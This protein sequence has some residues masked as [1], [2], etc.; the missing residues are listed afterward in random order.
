MGPATRPP[1]QAGESDEA[2]R[3]P[4]FATPDSRSLSVWLPRSQV[5]AAAT[6]APAA[7]IAAAAAASSSTLV[8]AEAQTAASCGGTS[9]AA[10]PQTS[11]SAGM[12][13]AT[14]GTPA[15]IASSTGRP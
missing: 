15:D 9:T 6:A 4:A 10:E 12:A 14:T 13:L 7:T 8:I 3:K 1:A 11:A 2:V 5:A